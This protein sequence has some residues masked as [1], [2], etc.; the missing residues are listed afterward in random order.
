MSAF[1]E[2]RSFAPAQSNVPFAP[3]A[4]IELVPI[5]A[6]KLAVILETLGRIV[7]GLYKVL[8][9]SPVLK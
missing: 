7:A 8:Q 4:D 6:N 5:T 9:Y 3:I 2:K 1:P